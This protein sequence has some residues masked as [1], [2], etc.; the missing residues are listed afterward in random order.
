M[1]IYR[2]HFVDIAGNVVA[3]RE[4]ECPHDNAAIEE[5]RLLDSYFIAMGFDL[6]EGDRLVHQ[7][8]H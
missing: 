2:A 6:F 1:A 8:R 5:A 4:I 3:T 7:Q